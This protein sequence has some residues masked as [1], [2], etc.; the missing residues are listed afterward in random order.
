MKINIYLNGVGGQGIGVL[1]ELLIR[2]YDHAGFSVKGVDTHGLAQRGGSVES[3]LRIGTGGTPLIEP[4]R[5]DIVLSLERTEALRAVVNMLKIGGSAAYYDASWQTLPVRL[6]DEAEISLAIMEETA[7]ERSVRLLRVSEE[8]LPDVRM[9]NIIL[10][11]KALKN[12]FLPGLTTRHVENSLEDLFSGA[13]LENNRM[14]LND[15]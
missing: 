5:A 10:L 11:S 8:N 7:A 6:G 3:H 4:G 12:G 15:E 2:S 9:Q 14:L 13:V 1:S